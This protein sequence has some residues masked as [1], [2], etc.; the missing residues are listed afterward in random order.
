MPDSYGVGLDAVLGESSKPSNTGEASQPE[1][2]TL[3]QFHRLTQWTIHSP[4]QASPEFLVI[5]GRPVPLR[6]CE[7]VKESTHQRQAAQARAQP[8]SHRL[9]AQARHKHGIGQ[10]LKLSQLPMP[11]ADGTVDQRR[12]FA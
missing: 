6:P 11:M 2:K 3:Q 5:A 1:F 10:Q 9:R 4:I 7:R 12:A 8:G